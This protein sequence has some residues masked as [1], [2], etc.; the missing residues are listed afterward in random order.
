MFGACLDCMSEYMFQKIKWINLSP[1]FTDLYVLALSREELLLNWQKSW[2]HELLT[3]TSPH[4]FGM[5]LAESSHIPNGPN[6]VAVP[7]SSWEFWFGH[8]SQHGCV[9]TITPGQHRFCS[10]SLRTILNSQ[11]VWISLN[12]FDKFWYVVTESNS[13]PKSTLPVISYSLLKRT[14]PSRNPWFS[15]EKWW[16]FPSKNPQL[17]TLKRRVTPPA[18]ATRGK[19]HV[20][21]PPFAPSWTASRLW[22]VLVF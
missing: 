11:C 14:W 15:H 1:Y 2:S 20:A 22:D 16:I 9:I 6:G 12:Q 19:S 18:D 5:I 13:T 8:A 21:A 3:Q 4:D 10:P 7:P 17:L